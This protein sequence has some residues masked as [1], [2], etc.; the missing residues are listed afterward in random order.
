MDDF[1]KEKGE[2]E[3]YIPPSQIPIGIPSSHWWWWYPE[4]P[5]TREID[6]IH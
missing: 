3:G 6:N 4:T 5:T 1:I 2:Y